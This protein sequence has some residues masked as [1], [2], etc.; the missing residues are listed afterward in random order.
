M[1]VTTDQVYAQIISQIEAQISQ[2]VPLLPKS[3]TRVL[4]KALAGAVVLVYKYAGF[5]FLQMFVR[6][7]S[8]DYTEVN[9]QRISPLREWG[10]LIGVGPPKQ[11][12]NA[13]AN[14]TITVESQ[15]GTLAAGS[16]LL[17]ANGV[18]YLTATSVLLDAPTKRV[19]VVATSDQ[20]GTGARGAIGNV[21][22][23]DVLTFVSPYTGVARQVTVVSQTVT[24]A[25]GES[26]EAYRQRVL[27]RFQK[28]PQGGAYADYEAWG[29]EVEGILNVYPYRS[30]Y[31]GQVDVYVEAT[32]ES[33]GSPDGVPTGAQL[34][35]VLDSIELDTDGLATRRPVGALVNAFPIDRLAFTVVVNGLQVPDTAEVQADVTQAIEEYFSSREPFI[36]GL[37]IPP[38]RDRITNSA[39]AGAVEDIVTANNGIFAGVVVYLGG[40]ESPAYSLGA[41]QKAKA[42]SVTFT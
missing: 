6:T 16:Q 38:R 5:M 40:V 4:A 15:G 7:A 33:S 3:F 2:Q 39:V 13:Q 21:D 32:P 11:P 41:G 35:A 8:I 37:T 42:L 29:E 12:T 9:G 25:D 23:G 31:P 19:E 1:S 24:G 27:D 30:Q 36:P 26:T 22:V 10:D 18:I 34:Q 14:V 20:A 28:R 17:G